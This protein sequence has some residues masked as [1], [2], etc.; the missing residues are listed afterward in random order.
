MLSMCAGTDN[1]ASNNG[2]CSVLATCSNTN[3][4]NK[5]T[6]NT[7]YTGDGYTCTGKNYTIRYDGVYLTY[8]KKLTGSQLCPPHRVICRPYGTKKQIVGPLSKCNTDRHAI[9]AVTRNNM[10]QLEAMQY[11]Q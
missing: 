6:C 1:C 4:G 3:S 5:C 11:R 8:S 2:G 7:G 10:H 9:P